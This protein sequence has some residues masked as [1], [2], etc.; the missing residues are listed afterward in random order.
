MF[1]SPHSLY[2][3]E[4]FINRWTELLWAPSHPL[5]SL[6]FFM[7]SFEK[8]ALKAVP[9][10][11][12]LHKW[13]VDDTFLIWLHSRHAWFNF[14]NFLNSLH[15]NIQFTM[16]IEQEGKLPFLDMWIKKRPDGTLGRPVYR[17]PT[18]TSLYW[19]NQSRHHLAQKVSVVSTLISRAY[20]FADSEH[21]A[22]EH[23]RLKAI[24]LQN[25]YWN[26]EIEQAL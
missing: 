24:F 18:H 26:P 23:E 1:H 17:K 8:M 21:M 14:V 6:I 13:H 9:F 19:N 10:I 12:A 5:S 16:E 2:I 11:P 7:E 25:G 3:R 22:E 15:R 20:W 4:H